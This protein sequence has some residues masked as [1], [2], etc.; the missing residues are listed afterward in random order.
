MLVVR[1]NT[2]TIG[3][4]RRPWPTLPLSL[5]NILVARS[6]VRIFMRLARLVAPSCANVL[7]RQQANAC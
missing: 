3:K 5:R 1:F 6:T 4:A 7:L 2:T